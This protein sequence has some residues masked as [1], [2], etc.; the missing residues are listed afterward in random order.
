MITVRP[1]SDRLHVYR[2]P[3][4]ILLL[5]SSVTLWKMQHFQGKTQPMV[6]PLWLPVISVRWSADVPVSIKAYMPTCYRTVTPRK[7]VSSQFDSFDNLQQTYCAKQHRPRPNVIHTVASGTGRVSRSL[8][9]GNKI[10]FSGYGDRISK[11][12]VSFFGGS[13]EKHCRS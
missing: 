3:D 6:S 12:G 10:N 4:A 7:P 9:I 8:E 2:V 13:L 11:F 1:R 5:S